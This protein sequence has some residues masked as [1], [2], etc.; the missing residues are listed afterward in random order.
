MLISVVIPTL[1]EAGMLA[2]T[3]SSART[4]LGACEIIVVDGGSTDGTQDI[5]LSAGAILLDVP[6]SRSEAM[7]AGART[8]TGNVLLF[9]HADTTLPSGAGAAIRSAIREADGGAFRLRFDEPSRLLDALVGFRTR[10]CSAVYGDQAIFV[11][12]A[13]FER[14]KGYRPL[15]IME[16][17]DLV[18]RIRRTGRFAILDLAVTTSTRRH[19]RGQLRTIVGMWRIQWLY[20][21][22]V[23][24]DRLARVYPPAR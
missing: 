8:A 18:E 4:A 7:N 3:I 16:D 21:L 9:L 15:P 22:G 23:S 5:A 10:W 12:R 13:E 2:T 11:T 24:P 19:R 14:L 20:K 6:G 17:Y 1:S